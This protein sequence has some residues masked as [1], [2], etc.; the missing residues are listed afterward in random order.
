MAKDKAIKR[1]R[2]LGTVTKK[3]ASGFFLTSKDEKV[4]ALHG[5]KVGDK[6]K[7][8][9]GQYVVNGGEKE[10][11]PKEA[12]N[13]AEVNAKIAALEAELGEVKTELG[14]MKSES[15]PAKIIEPKA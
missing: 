5:V 6:I 1:D 9:D 15:E 12:G 13:L 7:L 11:T 2:D 4:P 3:E 14:G 10:E 8:V